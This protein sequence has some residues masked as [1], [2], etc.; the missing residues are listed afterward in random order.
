MQ[1]PSSLATTPARGTSR[2]PLR[3][4]SSRLWDIK[5]RRI[6]PWT[7]EDVSVEAVAFDDAI[8]FMEKH[9]GRIFSSPGGESRFLGDPLTETKRRFGAEMDVFQ[10]RA[11]EGVIGLI[12]GHPTDWSTY[13]FRSAAF[14]PEFRD[15]RLASRLLERLYAPLREVGVERI[16]AECSPANMPMTRL[17]LAQGFMM[18]ATGN[19]ERWGY[20]G[21]FTKFLREEGETVFLR[22]Y[23]AASFGRNVPVS[24]STTNPRRKP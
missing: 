23:C 6:L 3:P 24:P 10:F 9:Y 16:D 14:L 5:W 7:F 11:P 15:R 12:M 20:M 17:F 2:A 21:R 18:T 19:S 4:L 8:P 1:Q 22:Q 13:Y